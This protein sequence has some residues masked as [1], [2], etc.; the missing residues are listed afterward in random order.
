L[1]HIPNAEHRMIAIAAAME[2]ADNIEFKS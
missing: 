1:S 2:M